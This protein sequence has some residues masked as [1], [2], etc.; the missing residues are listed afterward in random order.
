MNEI[1][2]TN[3][4]RM[5][6]ISILRSLAELEIALEDDDEEEIHFHLPFG[7]EALFDVGAVAKLKELLGAD[8]IQITLYPDEE[9]NHLLGIYY[10]KGSVKNE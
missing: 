5:N 3:L 9:N 10:N 4:K 2:E 7:K 1:V 8:R 6:G